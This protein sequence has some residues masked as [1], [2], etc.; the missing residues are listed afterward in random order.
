MKKFIEVI[1]TNKK[2]ILKRG[3]IIVGTLTGLAVAGTVVYVVKGR[4]QSNLE[5]DDAAINED[6]EDDSETDEYEESEEA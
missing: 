4:E 3:L 6:F 1:K 2:A 5:F